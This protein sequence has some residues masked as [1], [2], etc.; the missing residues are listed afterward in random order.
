MKGLATFGRL[1]YLGY[2]ATWMVSMMVVGVG[3][4]W[5]QAAHPVGSP[6]I[7]TIDQQIGNVSAP[8]EKPC[9]PHA[10]QASVA[11][12]SAK[13]ERA[14]E[15]QP[16]APAQAESASDKSASEKKKP[17]GVWLP[18]FNGKDLEGWTPKIRGYPL[19]ENYG[20][21]FRV[22]N[23]VLK[24][25][26]EPDKYPKFDNRFG[27]LFYKEK[28]SHYRLRVEYRFVGEQCPGG[29]GWAFRNSGM[30]IHC[31][32]PKTM[33]VEQSF[34]VSIE[35]QLL[36]G[37]GTGT[38]PTANLCTPGTHVV[39]DGKLFT[40]HCTDSRS[41]TYHGDRWVSV[42]VEVHGAGVIR[43][44]VEGQLV[45]E[46]EKP[47]LDDGDADAKRLLA[48]GA[49][50]L[51]HEGYISLQSESHPVEFRKVE[52]MFLKESSGK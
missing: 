48:A 39:M 6:E 24:V 15:T 49:D 44:Y 17:E 13:A 22:E 19:G 46:Y 2:Y 21:T 20:N 23:G 11:S 8:T 7:A 45:L 1:G 16:P 27:H 31:Q 26:Y 51:L 47:Q 37:R 34:P 4:R 38:R 25:V 5:T 41:P 35:V 28:F 12:A 42:E 9:C 36:G 40:P 10:A 18:L 32:D 52:I 29:P 14:G 3:S 33:T 30:M 50:R 43:H